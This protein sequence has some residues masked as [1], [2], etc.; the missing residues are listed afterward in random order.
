MIHLQ[1]NNECYS[2]VRVLSNSSKIKANP[3]KATQQNLNKNKKN[4]YNP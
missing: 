4:K 2:N 3:I 1:T